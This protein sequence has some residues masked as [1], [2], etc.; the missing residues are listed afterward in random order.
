MQEKIEKYKV[1]HFQ[2]FLYLGELKVC[3]AIVRSS[4]WSYIGKKSKNV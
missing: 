4:A 1:C 3:L 2:L